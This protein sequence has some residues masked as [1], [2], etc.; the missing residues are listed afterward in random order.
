VI[1]ELIENEW[2][3][4]DFID[5]HTVGVEQLVEKTRCSTGRCWRSFAGVGARACGSSPSFLRDAQ[6]WRAG[7]VDGHHPACLRR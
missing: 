1:K 3:A 7:L 5:Q 4:Q 2:V 6:N